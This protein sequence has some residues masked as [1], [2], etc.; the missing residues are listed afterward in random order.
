M[1]TFAERA[2][3]ERAIEERATEEKRLR[4]SD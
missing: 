4:K 2:I 1:A 3:E